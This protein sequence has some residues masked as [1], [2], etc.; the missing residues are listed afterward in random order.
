MHGL[1]S[2]GNV[3]V[4]KYGLP[5]KLQ[6][7]LN[8]E[9]GGILSLTDKNRI[10]VSPIDASGYDVFAVSLSDPYGSIPVLAGELERF[11]KYVR[12]ITRAKRVTLVGFSM[13]GVVARQ[14][15]V[16]HP[17]NHHVHRLI[18]IASPHQGSG[19]ALIGDILAWA[20]DNLEDDIA[21]GI[22]WVAKDVI[23]LEGF[24]VT[25]AAISDLRPPRSHS[26]DALFPGET[27]LYQ[28]NNKPHPLD[29]E[30][31]CV[32]V[33]VGLQSLIDDAME[34]MVKK[35]YNLEYDDGNKTVL[36]VKITTILSGTLS[37]LISA[38]PQGKID[39]LGSTDGVVSST[40]QDL[41]QLPF[42]QNPEIVTA[43]E[44]EGIPHLEA[45]V[46]HEFMI[47]ALGFD[48]P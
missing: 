7:E 14:Y 38:L 28:L 35:L 2:Q 42:F 29:I 19:L 12:K 26:N 25:S 46:E 17:R 21:K 24:E 32:I 37:K 30:Y 48:H 11:V 20:P 44:I 3:W 34:E 39:L 27:Y 31:V 22:N 13:G 45:C 47:E 40:S 36:A 9:F 16:D 4:D 15:V 6:Q 18:T 43:Y 5:A 1:G 41:R 23:N 33:R 10:T 8:L